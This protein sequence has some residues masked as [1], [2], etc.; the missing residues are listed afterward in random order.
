MEGRRRLCAARPGLSAGAARLHGRRRRRARAADAGEAAGAVPGRRRRPRLPRYRL[1]GDR[2]RERRA[3]R[4][5]GA[6]VEPRLCDVHLG[7]DRPAEGRD[8]PAPRARQLP[9]WAIEAY[10]V[11]AGGSV[12][13]HSSISFDL[14]VTSLYPALLAGGQVE[15]L[16]ED[17]GA[18]NLIAALR[19]AKNRTLVKITPA[20]LEL[21]G[22]A[23]SRPTRSSCMTPAASSSAARTCAPRTSRCGGT[24]PRRRGSSTST[25]RP[26]RWSAAASTRCGPDDPPRRLDPDRAADRQHAALCAWHRSRAGAAR[27]GR[28]ALHRRRR[29]GARLPQPAR[30]DGGALRRRPVLRRPGGAHVQA[31]ATSPASRPDGVLEY[32]GRVD[33]QVKIRGYRVE[34]GEIEAVLAGNARVRA[35][36]VL[37]REDAPGDKAACRL[38]GSRRRGAGG[39]PRAGAARLPQGAPARVHGAGAFHCLDALP[40]TRN[41]KIDRDALPAPAGGDAPAPADDDLAAHRDRADARRDLGEAPQAR[42]HRRRRGRVRSRRAFAAGDEG[43]V[44]HPRR[45]RRPCP[46]PQ[47]VRAPDGRRA[48]RRDRPADLPRASKRRRR[49]RRARGDP[50]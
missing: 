44:A 40:L 2:E 34:L 38:C 15:L 1:A 10:G 8:D 13:V 35:C 16:P 24:S 3:T 25:A 31:P 27:R 29:R 23:P 50:L 22:A 45:L 46:D 26:R 30:A 20:H 36:V 18:Q 49:R 39:R 19:R 21:L 6:A 47:P 43:A 4:R 9:H 5:R 33:S 14:T 41:G 7:L 17:A 42:A 28:R 32:L 48:C 37:A 12:P 11:A